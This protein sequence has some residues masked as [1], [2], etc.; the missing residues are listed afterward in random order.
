MHVTV[1]HYDIDK[2]NYCLLRLLLCNNVSVVMAKDKG[3]LR[4]CTSGD[5]ADWSKHFRSWSYT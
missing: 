5:T 3:T 2:H 1:I 4:L